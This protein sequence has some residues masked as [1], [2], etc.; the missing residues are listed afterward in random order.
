MRRVVKLP[1]G[2]SIQ[3]IDIIQ[4]DDNGIAN[5]EIFPKITSDADQIV[6]VSGF[7]IGIYMILA[8]KLNATG[9][10]YWPVKET[11]DYAV[12]FPRLPPIRYLDKRLSWRYMK[13]P[14]DFQYQISFKVKQ[15]FKIFTHA[16]PEQYMILVPRVVVDS[17]SDYRLLEHYFQKCLVVVC[18]LLSA[19]VF[20][21]LR[22]ACQSLLSDAS[23]NN[24]LYSGQDLFVDSFA[25]CLGISTG[26]WIARSTAE[27]Q[28]LIVIGL[29]GILSSIVISGFLYEQFLS[30]ENVEF[31][32][33]NIEEICSAGF[34]V[35]LPLDLAAHF[36][37]LVADNDLLKYCSKKYLEKLLLKIDYLLY[38]E[39]AHQFCFHSKRRGST[40]L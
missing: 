31:M 8:E 22:Y 34:K 29:Y 19:S 21:A 35:G 36:K 38:V 2:D 15:R 14:L 12:Q 23:R 10:S 20:A 32:Y 30:E 39:T 16:Q 17:S 26:S 11:I 9:F 24:C 40:A 27:R 25:R 28:L 13:K 4:G 3:V 7:R 1:P 5:N 33:N 6:F 18:L 37:E